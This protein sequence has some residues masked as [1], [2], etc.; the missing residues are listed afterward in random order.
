MI[1][2]KEARELT[3][4]NTSKKEME[5]QLNHILK[6]TMRQIENHAKGGDS[7]CKVDFSYDECCGE[8]KENLVNN[9]TEIGYIITVRIDNDVNGWFGWVFEVNW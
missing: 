5:D 8:N 2:A 3:E 1:T 9:L 4:S 6:Y 7:S